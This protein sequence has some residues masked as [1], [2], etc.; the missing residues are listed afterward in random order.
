MQ[1][2]IF[3]FPNL[4]QN[5]FLSRFWICQL[6]NFIWNYFICLLVFQVDIEL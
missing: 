3:K 5:Y 4:C 2:K 6:V 1:L